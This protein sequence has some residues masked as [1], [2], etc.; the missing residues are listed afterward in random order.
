MTLQPLEP[1]FAEMLSELSAAGAEFLLVGAYAVGAHVRPRATEDLDIWV[2]PTPENA[3]R[4]WRALARWGAPLHEVTQDDLSTL[5]TVFQIG[6]APHRI[7]ILT[8]ISG[9]TFDQ[10]WPNRIMAKIGDATYPVLG[11]SELLVN[12]RASGRPKDLIDVELLEKFKP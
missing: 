2:R 5:G 7:D 4:V 9:V 8:S 11:R 12:K 10:A 1:D 6:I 3:A